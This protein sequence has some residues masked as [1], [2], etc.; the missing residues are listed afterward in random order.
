[1]FP[2]NL[3][4]DRTLDQALISQLDELEKTI[5]ETFHLRIASFQRLMQDYHYWEN[6]NIWNSINNFLL[7][8]Y[9]NLNNKKERLE[10]FE[11]PKDFDSN[12]KWALG[13][14]VNG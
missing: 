2:A 7:T 4:K 1:T 10:I 8:T 13:F 5:T 11:D 6:E 14:D 3:E 12:F 9:N